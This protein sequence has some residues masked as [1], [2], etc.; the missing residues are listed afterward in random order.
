VPQLR[1]ERAKDCH[2][3]WKEQVNLTHEDDEE[4]LLMAR[5]CEINADPMPW[6][7][8]GSLHLHEPTVHVFLGAGSCN[9]DN[10]PQ[11]GWYLDTGVPSHM[12]GRAD[13]FS[14][15]DCTV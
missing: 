13:S 5:I 7:P 12:I 6:L 1:Q 14:L 15:L 9:G 4:S 2:A 3:P 11:E 10:E 8:E